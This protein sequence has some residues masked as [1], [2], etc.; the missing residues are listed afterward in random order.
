M[1]WPVFVGPI[2]RKR[3]RPTPSRPRDVGMAYSRGEALRIGRQTTPRR[4][5]KAAT[6]A[7][8]PRYW[9]SPPV[10]RA[11]RRDH[12]HCLCVGG[13][14]EALRRWLGPG[15]AVA[16]SYVKSLRSLFCPLYV[17]SRKYCITVH[18]IY[19]YLP[20]V[21]VRIT[22]LAFGRRGKILD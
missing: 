5:R 14:V 11:L 6:S 15:H 2:E 12:Q 10:R 13:R 18:R 4:W 17:P 8:R 22:I 9:V 20:K 1:S 3:H 16:E 21:V 7:P 19:H